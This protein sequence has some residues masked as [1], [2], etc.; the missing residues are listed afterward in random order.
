MLELGI[1]GLDR[2]GAD[3]LDEPVIAVHQLAVIGADRLVL[4]AVNAQVVVKE[5]GLHQAAAAVAVEP[6]DLAV[7]HLAGRQAGHDAVGKA[8]G[9]VDVVDRA[10]GAAPPRRRQPHHRRGRQL[11]H[12]VDVVDHQVQHHRHVVGAVGIGA[13]AARLEH[14]HLFTGDHLDQLAKGRVEALDVAHLQQ[15]PAR[16]G[17]ADQIG[18][19]LLAGG[20]RLLDQHMHTR[21]QAG[22]THPVVQ[23][24]RHGDAHRLHLAQHV[25]VVGK[26]AAAELLGRQSAADL[27]GV[28]HAHQLGILEQAQ[29]PGVVPAHV[30]DAD[31]THTHRVHGSGPRYGRII[32]DGAAG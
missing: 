2:G 5:I 10:L 21:L 13:V 7:G 6:A 24:G 17:G 27:V 25:A 22:Q 14:H 9:G 31:D 18:R 4:A 12:Q 3:L 26:P 11:E 19:F 8:Q 16:L 23:Q 30:A 29:H 28:G 32:S 20:D 1:E 15:P